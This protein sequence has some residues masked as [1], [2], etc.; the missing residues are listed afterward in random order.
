MEALR[1]GYLVRYMTLD[2]IVRELRQADQVG[3]LLINRPLHPLLDDHHQQQTG[4]R[5]GRAPAT[6]S[7]PSR[8]STGS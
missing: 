1:A 4:L 6:K 8:S 3:N 7:K 5:M 2:D